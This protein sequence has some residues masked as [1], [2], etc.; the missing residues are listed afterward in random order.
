MDV[1][2]CIKRRRSVR[3][4][5]KLPVKYE[6][7]TKILNAAILAP[8]AGNIQ[9]W[10]FIIVTKQ[11]LKE[12]LAEAALGQYWMVDAGVIIV[13]CAREKDSSARYGLRGRTLYCI[14]DTAAA[15]EN[16]LLAVTALGYGACWVGAFDEEAVRKILKIPSGVRPIALIPIGVPNE[17]PEP[18]WRMELHEV[19]H[20]EFYGGSKEQVL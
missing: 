10:E 13:V 12:E 15:I 19:I 18:R 11:E 9:P 20:F 4:F 14:Q 16:M 6:D 7:L 1:F 5:K 17:V 2:E 8:S 3:N